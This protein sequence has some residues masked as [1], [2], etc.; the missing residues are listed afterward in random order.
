LTFI[1]WPTY[2]FFD[3]SNIYENLLLDNLDLLP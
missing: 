1:T 2:E 3:L